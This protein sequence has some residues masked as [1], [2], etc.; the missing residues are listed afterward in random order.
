MSFIDCHSHLSFLS[1]EMVESVIEKSEK[2]GLRQW[3]MGGYDCKDWQKQIHLKKSF[4]RQV[5]TCFGLHPWKVISMSEEKIK[6][7]FMELQKIESQADLIGEVGMDFFVQRG[8]EQK[9]KQE[10]CLR[11]QLEMQ[12]SK[13][14]VFHVVQAHGAVLDILNDYPGVKGFVHSFSGSSEVAKAYMGKNIL[15][16]IGPQV[17]NPNFKKVRAALEAIDMESLLI[18]SDAPE[19]PD[20]HSYSLKLYFQVANEVAK[21]KKVDVQDLLNQVSENFKRLTYG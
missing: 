11:I 13:P 15:L 5:K 19:S 4:S 12:N 18:E 8:K 14:F 9:E 7:E 17:L 10:S 3:V 20:Q 21:L 2:M 6:S 1:P 16:S